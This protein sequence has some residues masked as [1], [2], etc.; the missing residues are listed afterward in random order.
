[1]T[2]YPKGHEVLFCFVLGGTLE[3]FACHSCAIFVVPI[4]V[5]VLTKRR[6]AESISSTFY[7]R[8]FR[9][10]FGAK[11]SHEKRASKTLMKL[12]VDHVGSYGR[13][14]SNFKIVEA[15]Y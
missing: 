8:V 2:P 15:S 1:L 12:T 5:Y 6:G 13:T 14:L 3:D 11:K 9:Q 10:Y 7:A 4:L